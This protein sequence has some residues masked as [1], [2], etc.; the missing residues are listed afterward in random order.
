[1]TVEERLQAKRQEVLRVAAKHGAR[2]VR[3]FGSVARGEADAESDID[4]LV[5]L[6]PGRTLFDLGGLQYELE[7]LL[8]CRVD[9]VTERGLKARIRDRVLQEAMLL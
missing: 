6:E 2:N 1:M 4:F 8:G 5:E 3:V 7:Q 9:V